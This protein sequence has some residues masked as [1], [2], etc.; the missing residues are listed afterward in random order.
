[1]NKSLIASFCLSGIFLLNGCQTIPSTN[2]SNQ[3]PQSQI[4]SDIPTHVIALPSQAA[5]KKTQSTDT[6]SVFLETYMPKDCPPSGNKPIKKLI[7]NF[8]IISLDC[9]DSNWWYQTNIIQTADTNEDIIYYKLSNDKLEWQTKGNLKHQLTTKPNIP[10]SSFTEFGADAP[11][12]V[13]DLLLD[14]QELKILNKEVKFKDGGLGGFQSAD[15]VPYSNYQGGT[16][17]FGETMFTL[18]FSKNSLIMAGDDFASYCR[19]RQNNGFALP[20]STFR[21][22]YNKELGNMVEANLDDQAE[23]A[24]YL[25]S[26]SNITNSNSTLTASKT[27]VCFHCLDFG[28]TPSQLTTYLQLGERD[29]VVKVKVAGKAALK[30]TTNTETKNK[31]FPPNSLT[32]LI[33]QAFR[34]GTNNLISISIT[35][36]LSEKNLMEELI[37]TIRF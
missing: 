9:A 3:L 13:L 10:W 12:K 2:L 8:Q 5:T 23:Q 26:F 24:K 4:I 19:N 31:F 32:Y 16:L 1:M 27:D 22:C 33:P 18:D 11:V 35:T 25:I 28:Q 20:F 37:K 15:F 6:Q 34:N 30:I 29:Q 17:F 7:N 21:F 36:M 14:G